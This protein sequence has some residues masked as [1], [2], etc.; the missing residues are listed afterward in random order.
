MFRIGATSYVIPADIL[1][2]VEYLAPLVDDIEL[3]LFE[4][5][6]H[7]S[8]L[9]GASTVSRLAGIAAVNG[10]SYTVHLPLDLLPGAPDSSE[11]LIKAARVI[12]ATRALSPLAYTL[13][14]DGRPL[15]ERPDGGHL[16]AQLLSAWRTGAAESLRRIAGW[17]GDPR[18]VCVENLE[19][20][21]PD[22]YAPIFDELPVSRTA[23]LGHLWLRGE[24]AAAVLAGWLDRTRVVHLH[25]VATRDHASLKHVRPEQLDPVVELL[26][27]RFTGVV[28]LEVFDAGDLHSSLET[29][30]A[31]QRR[32][33]LEG[34]DG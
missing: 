2:N 16:D 8:N 19:G 23:D 33:G 32:L 10:L 28:T 30:R 6:V 12:D 5:D 34:A 11:C 20:W 31:A 18:L 25:G 7:G 13:H 3:V 21:N 29:L 27:A 24:D 14:L 26:Q 9:P 15:L 17:V 22:L 1:P 4:T